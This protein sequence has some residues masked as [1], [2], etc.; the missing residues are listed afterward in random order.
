MAAVRPAPPP[1]D[2]GPRGCF[3]PHGLFHLLGPQ[4]E[5]SLLIKTR[6]THTDSSKNQGQLISMLILCRDG[7]AFYSRFCFLKKNQNI[8]S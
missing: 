3:L 4:P 8:F 5:F 2:A 7:I 1:L 6:H